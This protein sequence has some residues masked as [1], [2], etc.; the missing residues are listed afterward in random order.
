MNISNSS[1]DKMLLDIFYSI[2]INDLLLSPVNKF[3]AEDLEMYL[4][5]NMT[6]KGIWTKSH[7]GHIMHAQSKFLIFCYYNTDRFC[8]SYW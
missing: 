7:A 8:V 6:L 3:V 5:I 4:S 1:V 2:F